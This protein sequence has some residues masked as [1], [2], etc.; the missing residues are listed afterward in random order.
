[1]E[2]LPKIES[3]TSFLRY[4]YEQTSPKHIRCYRGQ[5][6]TQ[7]GMRPSVMRGLRTDAEKQ[8]F[9]ELMVESPIEFNDDRLMFDKLV[10]A[11]HYGL[12]TRLLD[13][14]LNPLVAL[15][16]ACNEETQHNANGVVHLLDFAKN[17][18]RF[19]DSDTISLISNLA[20]LTDA[21]KLEIKQ[22]YRKVKSWNDNAHEEFRKLAPMK[23]L[24]Q[25]IRVEKPYFTDSIIPADMFRYQFVYPA[26][27]NRRVIA[28]SGAF[29]VAGLL[30]YSAPG[31]TQKGFT[32][33]KIIIPADSKPQILKDLDVLNI[34]SRTMF[35][36][37]E[38]AAGYIK[39]KWER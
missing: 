39:R 1:M 9:S 32:A 28:Q 31:K 35:P 36:E 4:I 7:W 10:R 20:R 26:K 18:V 23:R 24:Y 13:V 2:L 30:E 6:N 22:E 37:V 38:F 25:F 11:Q 16:F 17:R 27:T 15:Y 19:S 5:S 33:S 3:V 12:P 8:I 14:S 29:L 21:E 34:N